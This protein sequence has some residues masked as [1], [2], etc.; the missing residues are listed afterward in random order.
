MG[1]L[2]TLSPGV[3]PCCWSDGISGQGWRI[4]GEQAAHSFFFWTWGASG[5]VGITEEEG[6]CDV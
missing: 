6:V 2:G 3:G 5:G 4:K 1:R